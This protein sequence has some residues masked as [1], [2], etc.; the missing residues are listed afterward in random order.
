MLVA[1]TVALSGII[2]ICTITGEII[3]EPALV[4]HRYVMTFRGHSI[5]AD[6]HDFCKDRVDTESTIELRPSYYD[7]LGR[8]AK[9]AVVTLIEHRE[10]N[11]YGHGLMQWRYFGPSVYETGNKER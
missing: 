6:S 10:E 2:E 11:D 7:K 9:G 8:P 1:P 5:S 3:S 4:D